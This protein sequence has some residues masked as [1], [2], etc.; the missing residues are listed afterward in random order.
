MNFSMIFMSLVL[1][2]IPLM[3]VKILYLNPP[4]SVDLQVP[5]VIAPEPAVSL[6]QLQLIKM[7][8]LQI[9]R[10]IFLNQSKCALES[11]K[12]YGMETCDPVDTPMVEKS[13]LDEDPQRKAIDPTRY[14]GMID[15]LM[16]LT[17]SRPDLVFA[18]CMCARS[19]LPRKTLKKLANSKEEETQQVAARDEKWVPFTERVKISSTNVRLELLVPQKW[20]G[21]FKVVIVLFQELHG[22]SMAFNISADVLNIYAANSVFLSRSSRHGINFTDVQ[23]DDT[24]ID[25]LIKLGYIRSTARLSLYTNMF[26]DHMHQPWRTL[27]TIINKCLSVKTA[28]NDSLYFPQEEQRK[29]SQRKK[30]ADDTQETVDVY[31]ES[32][33]EPEPVKRKTSSKIRVK[34]KVTL[35]AD[36]N[37]ISDDPD[38]ALELGKSISKTEAEEAEAARQLKGVPSLTLEEQEVAD[39]M[40]F[41]KE[42]KKT[43]KRQPGTRGSSEGIVTIPRV[44]NEST[45]ISATSSEG[46]EQESE[47]S[48]EDKLDDEEKDDKE[49]DADDED[50]ET[51]SDED[52]IY[53]YKIRVRK[54]E[55][56]EM[57]NAKVEDS[58]KGDEEVE[59]DA[60][61]CALLAPGKDFKSIGF[62]DQFLQLSSGSSL[63]SNVKDTTDAEINSL[64]ELRVAKLEKD[65]SK[66]KK[67]DLSAEA[68]AAL[69]TQVPS[70]VDNYLGSKVGDVFQKELKKHTA[71]LIQKYSL[72]QILELP[73]DTNN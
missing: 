34:K 30:T 7:H 55:D 4:P 28:S 25:F 19:M 3:T 10:G 59:R 66:L 24:A 27:A 14:R 70:V 32:E 52:D 6:P 22:A 64:L 13:E 18:V 31:E 62:G 69:K 58:D 68:L 42:S 17:S 9:P 67:I 54:D 23:N 73:K 50:D 39:I 16:Y 37:I 72:Q 26:V 47:Y 38:I 65:V 53:K 12:K 1:Y 45:I 35:S 8:H 57:L 60:C 15:T 21:H 51:E 61:K 56:E 11:L 71:N 44:P 29:G 36:D 33:P 41:L 63:M 20:K 49:G 46:T 43:S 5:P 40:Q 48:K 2:V